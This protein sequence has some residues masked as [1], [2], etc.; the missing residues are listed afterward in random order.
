MKEQIWYNE[1]KHPV[2]IET[3]KP[4]RRVFVTLQNK[5][6]PKNSWTTH[7]PFLLFLGFYGL[8]SILTL[9]R[10]PYM[11]SDEPWLG[12]L[13]RSMLLQ[14]DFSVTEPFL[15]V[16]TRYPHA[17]RILFHALQALVIQ[18][19]GFGLTPLRAISAT[20]SL[21]SLL[22]IYQLGCK[23]WGNTKA[24]LWSASLL[25][26]NIWF[27]YSAHF[28]RQEMLLVFLMTAG[29]NLLLGSLNQT[30]RWTYGKD[31]LLGLIIG[32]GV[33]LHPNSF[34]LA[35]L[36][37]SMYLVLIFQK[38]RKVSNLLVL[39]ATVGL[40]AGFFVLL[41]LAM[42]PDYFLHYAQN[43]E[44]FGVHR[45]LWQ[46]ILAFGT[47][48]EKMWRGVEMTYLIPNARLT[49]V[50]LGGVLLLSLKNLFL[51]REPASAHQRNVLLLWAA[52]LGL[53]VGFV[54]IGRFNPTSMVF[55]FPLLTLI[56]VEVLQ[57]EKRNNLLFF[58]LFLLLMGN[59]LSQLKPYESTYEAYENQI[60][61]W[62]SPEER[63]LA[64]LNLGFYFEEGALMDYRNLRHYR[65]KGLSLEEYVK[66][67]NIRYLFF[68]EELDR[69]AEK[70]PAYN[71][72]YGNPDFYYEELKV[73]L[74]HHCELV[75]TVSNPTYGVH[76]ARWVDEKAWTIQIFKVTTPP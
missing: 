70:K 68:A 75:G 44:K 15:D 48:L 52:L 7:L 8:F 61:A 64:N 10:Y 26:V 18:M 51:K 29:L 60:A 30:T 74:E 12:A 71:T 28:A 13:S 14:G 20:F 65:E 41:S 53:I 11:H 59:T 69:I 27:F 3:G 62:V 37:G 33:G 50:A 46:K 32:L 39:I 57:K 1:T 2:Q 43:G 34:V 19:F 6:K 76:V 9:T 58:L 66:S 73:F 63:S 22:M 24:G 36:F 23:L 49:L 4:E 40:V 67:R 17:I 56:S 5:E 21:G 16:Y 25:S 72:V 54:F 35:L 38:I 47:W 55:F 45:T 31:V 42:D